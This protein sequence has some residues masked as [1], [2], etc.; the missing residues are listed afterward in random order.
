MQRESKQLIQDVL[1]NPNSEH[2]IITENIVNNFTNMSD[3]E[4]ENIMGNVTEGII[5]DENQMSAAERL[6]EASKSPY[7]EQPCAQV[8]IIFWLV[9]LANIATGITFFVLD[10][11]EYNCHAPVPIPLLMIAWGSIAFLS[12]LFLTCKAQ[13]LK[14]RSVH[15][16]SPI[17]LIGISP[18]IYSIFQPNYNDPYDS[19]YC[20]VVL[21]WIAFS[22]V[23]L[24]LVFYVVFAVC[25]CRF[26]PCFYSC[27]VCER[28]RSPSITS[29]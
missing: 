3:D 21:Y 2:K 9:P 29:V 24:A 5:E 7:Q 26:A 22:S 13:S 18:V 11:P 23:T 1:I 4:T 10:G 20:H 12:A 27:C 15:L 6:A 14:L 25:I 28:E 8:Q 17:V 19:S 16:I